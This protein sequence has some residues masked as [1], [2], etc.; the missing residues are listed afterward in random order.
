MDRQE[1]LK[2]AREVFGSQSRSK[3]H[4]LKILQALFWI[5]N[6]HFSTPALVDCL[7]QGK[8]RGFARKLIQKGLLVEKDI[9]SWLPYFPKKILTLSQQ[10]RELLSFLQPKLEIWTG[11]VN[12]NKIFHDYLVQIYTLHL[13]DRNIFNTVIA[14]EHKPGHKQYDAFVFIEDKNLKI[15][16]EVDLNR[17]KT[18]EVHNAL[19]YIYQDLEKGVINEVHFVFPTQHY[20]LFKNQYENLLVGKKIYLYEKNRFNQYEKTYKYVQFYENW[21]ELEEH[22]EIKFNEIKIPPQICPTKEKFNFGPD[23]EI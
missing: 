10:G 3:R 5:N 15:G 12:E 14:R 13:L 19:Y 20:Q 21:I 17:K 4:E 6:F 7:T 1:A 22:G 23:I 16:I 11:K 8:K 2:Q 9:Y 18:R